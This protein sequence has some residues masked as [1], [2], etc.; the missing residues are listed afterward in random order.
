VENEVERAVRIEH[1]T[2]FMV[3]INVLAQMVAI[4]QRHITVEE[5]LHKR[6]KRME[7]MR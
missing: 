1:Y 4:W 6:Q 2:A 5:M 3:T 7:K